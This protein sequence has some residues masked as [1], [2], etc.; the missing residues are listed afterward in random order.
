MPGHAEDF[1]AGPLEQ[2]VVDRDREC[3]A[4]REQS[5]HDQIG[6]GQSERV[7]GPAGVG[8]HSVRAAVMPYLIQSGAGEVGWPGGTSPPGSHRSVRKPLDLYGSCHPG[9]QDHWTEGTH[10]QCANI[11]GYLPVIPCQ[12]SRAFFL[13]RSRLYFLRIQRIK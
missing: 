8:E 4:C 6:Q 7:A 11:R 12:H 13:P 3:G 10:F 5:G 2:R 9:L 1:L